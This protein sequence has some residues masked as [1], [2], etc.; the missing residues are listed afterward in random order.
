[1]CTWYQICYFFLCLGQLSFANAV[2]DY[3][4]MITLSLMGTITPVIIGMVVVKITEWLK[5]MLWAYP[6]PHA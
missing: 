2:I 4:G 6:C 5:S 3:C 1:M